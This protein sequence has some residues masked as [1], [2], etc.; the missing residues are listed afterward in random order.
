[1][2]PADVRSALG[3]PQGSG[4]SPSPILGKVRIWRYAGLRISFDSVNAGRTVVT[5]ASTPRRARAAGEVGV[6]SPEAAVQHAVPGAVCATRLGY[7]TCMVGSERPGQIVTDFAISGAGR[8]SRV[9][10]GRVI[11]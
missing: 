11:D 3:A 1:M 9:T 8:V 6:G 4:I 7:R 2:T 5:V 10:L